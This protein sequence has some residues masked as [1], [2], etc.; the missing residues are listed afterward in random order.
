MD[1]G[2]CLFVVPP[3]FVS[4]LRA[5]HTAT[6]LADWAYGPI[7]SLAMFREYFP[8][9]VPPNFCIMHGGGRTETPEHSGSL[10]AGGFVI[11]AAAVAG[12]GP[13]IIL[14]G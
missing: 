6:T 5:E 12:I 7:T 13:C 1:H 9:L 2:T 3:D 8:R 11:M 4:R 10:T 14:G